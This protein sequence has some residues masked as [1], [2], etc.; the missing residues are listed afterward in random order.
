MILHL[1]SGEQVQVCTKCNEAKSLGDF[2]VK[3]KRTGRLFTWCKTC[4]IEMTN[5]AHKRKY[6]ADPEPF[7]AAAKAYYDANKDEV[8]AKNRAYKK[9]NRDLYREQE[10]AYKAANPEKIRAKKKAYAKRRKH[11]IDAANARYRECN[12]EAIDARLKAWRE[13]NAERYR[14]IASTIKHRRRAR[15]AGAGGS[16]TVA[17]WKALKQLYS[18]TCPYCSRSEPEIKLTKD[19]FVPISKGGT[20]D[21]GNLVPACKSCNSRKHARILEVRP[22]PPNAAERSRKP[23]QAGLS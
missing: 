15:L 11:V 6:Q 5:A 10:R 21:I 8:L 20:D 22:E 19:H 17:E 7:K 3:D 14:E 13:A 16:H 1:P 9:A 18:Y 23:R 12:R 4:H 2:C